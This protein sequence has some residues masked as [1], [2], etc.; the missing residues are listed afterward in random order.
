MDSLFLLSRIPGN[1]DYERIR[2]LYQLPDSPLQAHLTRSHLSQ[3]TELLSKYEAPQSEDTR[4]FLVLQKI[5]A[6]FGS[7]HV[8]KTTPFEIFKGNLIVIVQW[9]GATPGRQAFFKPINATES[10]NDVWVPLDAVSTDDGGTIWRICPTTARPFRYPVDVYISWWLGGRMWELFSDELYSL[11]PQSNPALRLVPPF[12]RVMEIPE[13]NRRIG[14]ANCTRHAIRDIDKILVRRGLRPTESRKRRGQEEEEEEKEEKEKKT[15]AAAAPQVA[16]A[17]RLRRIVSLNSSVVHIVDVLRLELA[18]AGM[19]FRRFLQPGT[20]RHTTGVSIYPA[21]LQRK[22][23][24]GSYPT[25]E[26]RA[27]I[28]AILAEWAAF[29][30]SVQIETVQYSIA[31]VSVEV[32]AN[33]DLGY[34]ILVWRDPGVI[35][36]I[37][38]D[39]ESNF[40]KKFALAELAV[41]YASPIMWRTRTPYQSV[42]ESIQSLAALRS[43]EVLGEQIKADSFFY[44]LEATGTFAIKGDRLKVPVA[45][46]RALFDAT[47]FRVFSP[48]FVPMPFSFGYYR[49]STDP[50]FVFTLMCPN[51]MHR[52]AFIN[53]LSDLER[54]RWIDSDG[55]VAQTVPKVYGSAIDNLEAV[56]RQSIRSHQRNFS[57]R[58]LINQPAGQKE[59]LS[60]QQEATGMRLDEHIF[61]RAFFFLDAQFLTA[62]FR[63]EYHKLEVSSGGGTAAAAATAASSC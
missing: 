28:K 43:T 7:F 13:I 59:V 12:E 21:G 40:E 24:V 2:Q 37:L 45:Q 44:A 19:N 11:P 55:V 35:H 53:V 34:L 39:T 25:D 38:Y 16:S 26:D 1:N 27:E 63:I 5:A 48:K 4:V 49:L 3:W 22:T 31:S 41:K 30:E 17:P 14:A 54:A 42:V 52:P 20:T 29:I 33:L 62:L 51:P 10:Q 60:I 50:A 9:S 61:G 8:V 36:R 18:E 56:L 57:L 15:A 46:A 32:T 23:L 6:E 47:R 58:K